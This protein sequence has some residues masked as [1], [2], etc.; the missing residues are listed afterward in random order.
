MTRPVDIDFW[1]L[2]P[3]LPRGAVMSALRIIEINEWETSLSKVREVA[4]REARDNDYD[5]HQ[6]HLNLRSGCF[7]CE[8]EAGPQTDRLTSYEDDDE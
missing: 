7:L 8:E 2:F 4:T 5:R 6:R 1:S 3:G